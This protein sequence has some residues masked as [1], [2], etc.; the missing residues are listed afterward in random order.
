METDHGNRNELE[1]MK[2]SET[3]LSEMNLNLR[4]EKKDTNMETGLPNGYTFKVEV[5]GLPALTPT[6]SPADTL[7]HRPAVISS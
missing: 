7:A 2:L 6:R 1:S 5:N 3:L 4:K